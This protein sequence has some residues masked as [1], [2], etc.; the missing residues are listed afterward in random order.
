M[1]F[2]R[3]KK[4][5]SKLIL[6]FSMVTIIPLI[7]VS[8]YYYINLKESLEK[9]MVANASSSIQY[10]M[11]NIDK[12]LMLAIQ[13]SD[14]FFI[15][16]HIEKALLKQNIIS[17]EDYYNEINS[18]DTVINDQLLVSPVTR[19]ISALII[20]GDNGIEFRYGNDASM[21][22]KQQLVKMPWFIRGVSE[23]NRQTWQ[24]IVDNN[25][26]LTDDKYVL[27]VA[28][29]I[30]TS[31]DNTAIGW[32]V[33][34]FKESLISDVF[35]NY[36][37]SIEKSLYVMD[38][39]GKC[40]SSR[41][42]TLVGKDLSGF[43]RNKEILE[44][45]S[46]SF[47]MSLD[48]E[49]RLIV[50]YKSNYTGWTIVQELLYDELNR[51][52]DI[53][54]GV[55][56][57]VLAISILFSSILIVFLSANLTNP[58]KKITSRLKKISKGE[59]ERDMVIEGEDELGELGGAINKMA[60]NIKELLAKL[61]KDEEDKRYLE[62]MV[63]Q[64]QV[65]PHFL[66]NTLNS[67]KWMAMVQKAEGI[68]QMVSSLGRLL[69]NIAK[70]TSDRITLKEELDLLDDYVFIQ[71]IRYSGRIKMQKM[72]EE[73][74]LLKCRIL[75]LTLQ[76]IVENAIFHGIEPKK[77]AGRIQLE[78]SKEGENLLITIEDDGI[79]ISA[80]KIHNLFEG[81]TIDKSK[82]LNNIGIR[83]VDERLKLVYGS[84]Y[85]LKISS[86]IGE[87]TRV[88]V[89]IPFEI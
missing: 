87:F 67:I 23:R 49:K 75:K 52:N 30:L 16:R 15:N 32:S 20:S 21:I 37:S 3:P 71:N 86:E 5:K 58:L 50:F 1:K 43:T 41:D 39:T 73:E 8:V 46:G 18:I 19:Y 4:M 65:N 29:P 64:Q 35:K 56:L 68:A 17:S 10:I 82:G 13:L 28:R 85:G 44:K 83:N 78:V 22:D 80:E 12:Q 55:T 47:I 81:S 59:F 45:K 69:K 60:L 25:A 33:I 54:L 26:I 74:G 62:I 38:A 77:E 9:S 53:L 40:I 84:G 48:K 63:L 24:G 11:D 2:S 36:N 70:G 34:E 31:L 79:G 89:R 42:T 72:I 6:Y 61:L 57:L 88:S 76:P 14:W 51:Q 27:P 66:Y 7:M